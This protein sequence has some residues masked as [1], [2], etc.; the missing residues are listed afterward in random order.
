MSGQIY[1]IALSFVLISLH[2]SADAQRTVGGFS[3]TPKDQ[4][5]KLQNQLQSSIAS[6][7][8]NSCIKV[9]EIT[10]AKQ[11]VVAGVNY[12]IDAI[13]SENKKLY[14]CCFR[15]FQSL[16]PPTFEVQCAYCGSL[17]KCF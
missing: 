13:L 7:T 5:S 4:Y 9:E 10:R 2:L 16:P 1:I 17:C 8:G 12:L 6:G 14:K 15:V 3:P 11:Q